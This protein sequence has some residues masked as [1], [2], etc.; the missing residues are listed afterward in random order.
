MSINFL[1]Q[2]IIYVLKVVVR[3]DVQIEN[4]LKKKKKRKELTLA[5]RLR[6]KNARAQVPYCPEPKHARGA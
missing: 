5:Y 1:C 4:K 6:L 3:C 2:L